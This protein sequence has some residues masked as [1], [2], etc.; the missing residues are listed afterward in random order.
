[1]TSPA[2]SGGA[3]TGANPPV[4]MALTTSSL[5]RASLCIAAYMMECTKCQRPAPA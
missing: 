1:M 4:M 3:P 5:G 2:A